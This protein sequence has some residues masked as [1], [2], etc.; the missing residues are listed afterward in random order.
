MASRASNSDGMLLPPGVTIERATPDDADTFVEIHEEAARLLWE[1][2]IRQWQPGTFQKA[3]IA[4]PIERGE[5]YLARRRGEALGTVLL[6]WAD[7]YTWG[8][9]PP[10]AGYIH[11]LRVRRSVAGQGL[12]RTMLRWAEREI[13]QAGRPLARLDCIAGNE[14]LCAYYLAA[15]YKR[16]TDLEW[17]EGDDRGALARFEKHLL[18]EPVVTLPSGTL[19]IRRAT[20][21]DVEAI[22]AIH[23]DTMRWTFAQGFRRADPLDLDTLRADALERIAD[24]EV[25]VAAREDGLPI[26]TFA[27]AWEDDGLWSDMPG[28]AAYLFA[29][30]V[31]RA[32]A[33]EGVGHALLRWAAGRVA[34]TGTPYLRLEC[35]ADNPR[36]RAYYEQAGFTF[37]G[38]AHR[39]SRALA[40]Y[41]KAVTMNTMETTLGEM[42]VVLAGAD[43][44]GA[45]VAIWDDAGAWM[46]SR[47][48]VAEQPPRP[49][50]AIVS[51]RVRGGEAYLGRVNG[52]TAATI[53]LEWEDDGVWSDLP[54][55]ALYVHG[56]AS[57]RT[58][59]G[60]G[61]ALLRWAERMAAE[62]GRPLLRLDC[63]AENLALR[64][65]YERAGFTHRGD[66]RLA[67]RTAAR[68]ER[69]TATQ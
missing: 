48:I 22:A 5:L 2:G 16:T 38:E 39:G 1:Q 60:T 15:G 21:A 13:A 49:M 35:N 41:E 46:R 54:S 69:S 65:Y 53:T 68:F 7:E 61:L 62:A 45:I 55:E 56:L 8:E 17:A 27:L 34:A 64:A 30:A 58:Y 57:K 9:Q 24:H 59:A 44:V 29:F 52:E 3:W 26:A 33:G 12:G 31:K 20:P 18:P 32:F 14:R 51:D 66:V 10:D 36:L 40:R 25:Y 4:G 47:G 63:R 67:D 37:R 19:A 43:D 50:H 42:T 28:G 23:D 11:G 6:Q